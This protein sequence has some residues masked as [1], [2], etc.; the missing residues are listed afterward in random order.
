MQ[1]MI[2][3]RDGNEYSNIQMRIEYSNTISAFEYS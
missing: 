2:Y 1:Y 3:I